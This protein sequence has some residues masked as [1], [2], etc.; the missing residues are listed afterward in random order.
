[1][2]GRP[3]TSEERQVWQKVTRTVSPRQHGSARPEPGHEEFMHMM[4]VPPR[5]PVPSA[6]IDVDLQINKDRKTRRGRVPVDA[7]LDLHDKTQAEAW[8]LLSLSV[9]RSVRRGHK[10]LLVI[11]GKGARLDGVLR[12]AFP[13][14]INAPDI[15]PLIASYAQ[16]HIRHGGSGAWYVFLKSDKKTDL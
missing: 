5:M 9:Q 11:T 16:A 7:K 8:P 6:A 10:C 1:M 2:T 15:R 4:R 14:W 3:L 12:R 13:D